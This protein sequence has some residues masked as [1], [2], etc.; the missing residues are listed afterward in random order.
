VFP[1]ESGPGRFGCL[2][3]GS[4]TKIKPLPPPRVQ[5]CDALTADDGDRLQERA[6]AAILDVVDIERL[7]DW[8]L[9]LRT[10]VVQAYA[11]Q[12]DGGVSLIDTS[13]AGQADAILAL[14][15]RSLG[16]PL[17][18][19]DIVLTHGHDDHTGSAAALARHTGARVFG[20]ALEADVIEGRR[21]REEPRLLDWERPIFEQVRP[22][23]PPAPPVPLDVRLEPGETLPW[24]RTASLVAAPGHTAGQLVVWLSDD[25]VLV[26]ADALASHKGNPM[27]GVFNVDPAQAAKTYAALTGLDP[28]IACF[29]HGE[30]LL[31][32]AG[33][34]LR[35][36]QPP[37]TTEE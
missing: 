1:A 31:G 3:A 9:C 11:V 16:A 36:A 18:L 35:S 2:V 27:P 26:A 24:D 10:P 30:P 8:L 29:G 15:E 5:R 14:L 32:G 33:E 37:L 19:H 12:H 23:V 7:T 21:E 22:Q 6:S 13:T 28:E 20:P 34:R 4:A 25:R 17:R